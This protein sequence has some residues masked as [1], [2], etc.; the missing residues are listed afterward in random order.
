M[1]DGNVDVWWKEDFS[2]PEEDEVRV[3]GIVVRGLDKV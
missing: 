1:S 3:A 2:R